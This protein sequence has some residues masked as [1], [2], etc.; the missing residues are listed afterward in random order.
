MLIE[1]GTYEGVTTAASIYEAPSG[2]VMCNMLVDIGGNVFRGGIC[3]VQ[4]DGTLSERGFKDAAAILEMQGWDWGVWEN[5]PEHFAGH[6]VQAVVDTVEGDKGPFSSIKYLNP[7]GGGSRLE[8]GDAKSLAAKYGAKTRAMMGGTP[9]AKPAATAPVKTPP[10]APK[11][12]AQTGKTVTMEDCWEVFVKC[13]PT[14]SELELY[15]LWAEAI[16]TA[17]GKEQNDCNAADWAKVLRHI[18]NVPMV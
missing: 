18:D 16:K 6:A 10:P 2:A 15:A 11:P 7:P 5:A 13:N 17:A 1:K 14:K 12:A 8:K 3:L 9:A 4:K